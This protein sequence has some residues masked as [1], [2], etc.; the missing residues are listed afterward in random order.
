M[1]PL[2][3][4]PMIAVSGQV[5]NRARARRQAVQPSGR[6]QCDP[7]G[8]IGLLASPLPRWKRTLD[9]A[10]AGTGLLLLLPLLLV[11]AFATRATSAGGAIFRQQRTG[12]RL[13]R[14][15]I[16]KFRSMRNGAERGLATLQA[17]NQMSGPLFKTDADPASHRSGTCCAAPASTNCRSC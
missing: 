9:I 7:A 15:S 12:H 3:S 8:V 14:F 13:E 5:G 4:G 11:I 17:F 6:V 1:S 10:I 16:Y 2:R